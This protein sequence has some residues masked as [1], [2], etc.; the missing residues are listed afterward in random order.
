MLL[1]FSLVK[2]QNCVFF[3][4]ISLALPLCIRW[5]I[6]LALHQTHPTARMTIRP[7][8]LSHR[9]KRYLMFG[10]CIYN[11]LSVT[12]N[13]RSSRTRW[14]LQYLHLHLIS[15]LFSTTNPN[16]DQY[17]TN[18]KCHSPTSAAI[19]KSLQCQQ[20]WCLFSRAKWWHPLIPSINS[21]PLQILP[22]PVAREGHGN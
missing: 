20:N 9:F 2:S 22:Y 10:L 16:K 12:T 1:C 13:Q 3:W 5:W 17:D 15:H 6:S 14:F 19:K 18:K 11:G 8:H 21:Q 7:K 4:W